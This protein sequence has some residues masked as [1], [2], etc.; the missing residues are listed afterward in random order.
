MFLTYLLMFLIAI[1]AGF[2]G[3]LVGVG[4][5]VIIVPALSLVFHLPI[6]MAIAASIVSVIATSIAGALSYV[7]QE[8]TN[9][10]LGMFLEIATTTGALIGALIGVLLNGWILSMI[11]GGLICYMAIISY[12]TRSS[13]EKMI[14]SGGY[15][16]ES[17]DKIAVAL[18]LHG[19]YHDQAMK[20]EVHYHATRTIEGSL[21]SSL[22]GIG[23]G[24]LGIGGGVIKV[25]AMNSFM[26]IPMK[27]AVATSKFMIGVTAATSA[28]VYFLAG[29]IDIYVVAPVALGTMLGAT[30]G[31][32]VMNK[33]HSKVIKTIF[34]FL[35][36]YLGYQMIAK[37][38][39]LKFNFNLP[40]TL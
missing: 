10:K 9:I 31:S 27:A 29:G 19:K 14:S 30:L 11:F 33:L 15:S 2:F 4:G 18:K 28:V 23:S 16:L 17:S 35:M 8:I 20:T 13:E 36:I 38:V 22:A 21:V 12:K 40:G 3:A 26:G 6:H 34:F 7:E 37:G 5:G 1:F 24:L 39:L 25:A 32:S